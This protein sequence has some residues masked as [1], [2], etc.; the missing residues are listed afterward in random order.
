MKKTPQIDYKTY[1]WLLSKINQKV[2]FEEQS[3]TSQDLAF[4][5]EGTWLADTAV[6]E[7][8]TKR[9]GTYSINLLFAHY[10]QPLML[11][12]RSITHHANPRK[13]QVMSQL[14]RRQAAKDQRGT[15]KI[16]ESSFFID[17]N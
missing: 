5:K 9:K 7:Y 1:Q 14:F 13:A 12:I 3:S 10:K 15:L 2:L 11:L 8:L 16:E 4:I 17:Y 6:L